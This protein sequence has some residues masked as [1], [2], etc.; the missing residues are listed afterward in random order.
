M[1]RAIALLVIG[2]LLTSSLCAQGLLTLGSGSSSG[3]PNTGNDL[4]A[5]VGKPI[6]STGTTP[7]LVIG[8]P[9]VASVT[10]NCGATAG[11]TSVVIVGNNIKPATAVNFGVTPASSFTGG[12]S[13]TA[14]SPAKTAGT[15]DVTVTTPSGTSPT[16]SP[17]Q[18]TYPCAGYTGPG[19]VVSGWRFWYGLRGYSAAYSTG[20]NNAVKLRRASD[21]TTTDFVVLSNGNID[22]ASINTFANTNGAVCTSSSIS[23]TTLTVGG[24]TGTP[25]VSDTISGA[26]ITQPAFITSIGTCGSGSGTCTLNVSQGTISSETITLQD[27]LFATE[28]YDQSGANACSSAPCH[29]TQATTGSQPQYLP[30][31][32]NSQPCLYWFGNQ[33]LNQTG[34]TISSASQ[35]NTIAAVMRRIANF[36]TVQIMMAT[37]STSATGQSIGWASTNQFRISASASPVTATMSDSA[38]HSAMAV[39]NGASSVVYVDG[40][41]SAISSP[42]TNGFGAGVGNGI[43]TNL[44]NSAPSTGYF[45]EGGG[46]PSD[47]GSSNAS[48]LC[49]N[50]YLYWGS[51]TWGTAC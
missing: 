29:L 33:G 51:A 48:N 30:N 8:T 31:C 23:G 44:T 7:I 17:D 40:V 14:T 21:A 26:G 27:A 20:S 3:L 25:R 19:D 50:Q 13:V 16:G 41:S 39:L 9:T 4:L 46:L 35:P 5:R 11:G 42:G 36:T 15:Y 18:F 10:P 32:G 45:M 6:F 38:L 1:Q 37:G 43:G 24:C 2:F 28:I 34:V 49:H 47:I 22:V 12:A